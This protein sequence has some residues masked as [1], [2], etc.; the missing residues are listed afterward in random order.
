VISGYIAR[1]K[2]EKQEQLAYE[3]NGSNGY[4]SYVSGPPS[5]PY[6][7]TTGAGYAGRHYNHEYATA[8]SQRGG[9]GRGRGAHSGYHPYQRPPPPYATHKFKNKS[10]TFKKQ[11]VTSDNSEGETVAAVTT[12]SSH[13]G[14]GFQQH[15][16]PQTLCPAFTMT[17]IE[18]DTELRPH[19]H[20]R[21]LTY[22]QVYVHDTGVAMPTIRTS[23]Q[24]ASVGSLKATVRKETLVHSLTNRRP[25]THQLASIFRRVA[26]TTTIA[27]SHTS[28]STLQLRTARLLGC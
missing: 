6:R 15:S 9:Y 24:S 11:D 10:V 2:K 22:E 18:R 13:A 7:N 1:M 16:E 23:K 12:D 3:T 19:P 20:H 27:G 21:R 14:Q 17:G 26:A 5:S 28:A 4:T 25:T 8:G